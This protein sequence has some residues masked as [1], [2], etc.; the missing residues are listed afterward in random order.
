MSEIQADNFSAIAATLVPVL[1]DMAVSGTAREAL[2]L[3][4]G[5]DYGMDADSAAAAYFNM[6][7]RQP[8]RVHVR[9]PNAGGHGAHR[10]G[11]RLR[12]VESLLDN[13]TPSG[14]STRTSAPSGRDSMLA[15][16]LTRAAAEGVELMG[17]D[18]T[19]WRWGRIHTLKLTNASFGESGVAP[20]E[21]LFNRGPYEVAGGSSVVNAVGWEPRR[22]HRGLG[23]VDAAGDQPRRLGRVDLGEPDRAPPGTPSTRN[24]ADQTPL[25]QQPQDPPVGVQRGCRAEG[26][27]RTP[28]SSGRRRLTPRP[29]PEPLLT[30]LAP[31]AE[32]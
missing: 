11:P 4:D 31:L 30:P 27:S 9:P 10:R 17:T 6:V 25:W 5:W 1:Q 7:W 28:C 8:A 15:R 29:H 16:V 20:I 24:Y 23:A 13:R 2:A 32:L 3:F 19:T 21:W 26:G 12:V 14:G 22:V 18:L